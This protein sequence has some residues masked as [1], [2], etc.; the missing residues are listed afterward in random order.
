[1]G[2]KEDRVNV[3]TDDF[4]KIRNNSSKTVSYLV[5]EFELRKN[6]DQLKRTTTAKTGDLNMNKIFSYKFNEDIFKKVSVNPGGKSHGLVMFLDWSG[7]M[8]PHIDNT[9]K[10][11]ISLVLFCKKVNI[12][13]EVYAFNT[14]GSYYHQHEQAWYEQPKAIDC[15]SLSRFRLLN[16]LSS[17]MNA[18]ELTKS[19]ASL[20]SY[21]STR[22]HYRPPFLEM[23][24]T[25]LNEAIITAMEIVPEFKKQNRL[26]IVNTV[27]LTD[28][29]GSPLREVLRKDGEGYQKSE[30][31]YGN[32]DL[33]IVDPVTKNE[34]LIKKLDSPDSHT[35]AYLKLFKQRTGSNV[36]GFYIIAGRDFGKSLNRWFPDMDANMR[37]DVKIAF[38][39]NKYKVITNAGYDEYYVLRSEAMDTEE[40]TELEVKENAT[41]RGLVS[42]FNK[43][44]GGRV[45][46]RVVL[47]KFIG[48][49]A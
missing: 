15:V 9:I 10:Q 47:N 1:M 14:P 42:A 21:I 18:S 13:Y 29:E 49:I 32:H 48:M 7:S 11:L 46:S 22:S 20:I 36:V 17:R 35:E 19:C 43:Y 28:G 34:A 3:K 33:V 6:A 38:R 2:L 26:Q 4:I 12:P 45:S 41:T 5:K 16:L 37:E 23:G 24:G 31:L 27:F 8:G 44:A 25:P 40:E 30:R 39:K